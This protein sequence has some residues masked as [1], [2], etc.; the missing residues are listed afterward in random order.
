MTVLSLPEM[1]T[2]HRT[3]FAERL[4]QARKHAGLSQP[5]LAKMVGLA[6]STIGDLEISGQGSSKVAS[7][8]RACGVRVLWLERGEGPMTGPDDTD[9][10]ARHAVGEQLA[11]YLQ[12]EP[13]SARDYRTVVHSMAEALEQAGVQ[14]SVKQ[15]LALA[16][17][18]YE[19]YG[20]D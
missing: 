10:A 2:K 15:F 5:Q 4:I 3:D 6:Q 8:A 1:R 13:N 7:L 20:R 18:A 14:V 12:T 9:D 19:K 11:P 17:A 16:D